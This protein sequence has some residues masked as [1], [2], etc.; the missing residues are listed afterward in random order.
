MN[1][2]E[3]AGMRRFILISCAL[4][5]LAQT[6]CATPPENPAER[7]AFKATNDPLEPMNRE[8]FGANQ[9]LDK[10]LFEPVAETYSTVVP[11]EVRQMVR[12]MLNNMNEPLVSADNALQGE[13][14]RSG[15]SAMRFGFNTV[16]G[17]GGLFDFCG[18]FGMGRE[19]GDFGQTLYA[20]GVDDPGPYLVLPILGPSTP[21]D[22][23]GL[24]VDS[25]IDPL[26]YN[27]A[28]TSP[29]GASL[30]QRNS[31]RA[32]ADGIDKRTSALDELDEIKKNS[33]DQYAQLRSLYRQN[34]AVELRH[35]VAS[36]EPTGSGND[37]Y[38]D[39]AK[40][41]AP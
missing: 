33:V 31:A 36:P 30:S 9:F 38:E 16:F 20:W 19:N 23:I 34:R 18:Q 26:R 37:L 28:H 35:G 14:G 4:G 6:G 39:P 1:N 7:A 22:G 25:Y 40:Q 3:S 15:I 24:A 13:F 17:M 5:L 10:Y 2:S 41:P 32:S 29:N 8:I 12:N 27:F 11:K 21:R